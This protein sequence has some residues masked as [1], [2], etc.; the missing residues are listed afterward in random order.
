MCGD[1]VSVGRDGV[2]LLVRYALTHQLGLPK[3]A[4]KETINKEL[5]RF[6]LIQTKVYL[7]LDEVTEQRLSDLADIQAKFGEL[8]LIG[9]TGENP[10][11]PRETDRGIHPIAPPLGRNKD[12]LDT[13]HDEI[14][15]EEA[16][17]FC[18]AKL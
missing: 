4:S 6:S 1:P 9:M 17:E 8:V 10:L 15:A 7:V 11:Q 14:A 5:R 12:S 3:D 16:Y 13:F 2:T 18:R